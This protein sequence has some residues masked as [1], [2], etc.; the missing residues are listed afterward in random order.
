MGPHEVDRGLAIAP[1]VV[2][3]FYDAGGRLYDT[4]DKTAWLFRL[5][6]LHTERIAIAAGASV[7]ARSTSG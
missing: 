3:H 7:H 2:K 5:P 6:R 4:D 1:H